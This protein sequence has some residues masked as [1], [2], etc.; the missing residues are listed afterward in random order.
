VAEHQQLLEASS[1]P[2]VQELFASEPVS[3]F[4]RCCWACWGCC[5]CVSTMMY[6]HKGS[7]CVQ[8]CSTR[9]ALGLECSTANTLHPCNTFS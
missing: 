7:C 5:A 4:T 3:V 1:R 8:Y 6:C 2:F 9:P